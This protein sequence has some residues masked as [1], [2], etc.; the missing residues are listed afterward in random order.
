M[1][2]RY[3]LSFKVGNFELYR[4]CIS[5]QCGSG[6]TYY[7]YKKKDQQSVN[8]PKI[9]F[10]GQLK[11]LVCHLSPGDVTRDCGFA[12]CLCSRADL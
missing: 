3:E 12:R 6:R 2:S 9:R 7:I 1:T 11:N 5:E 8:S 4:P 10:A